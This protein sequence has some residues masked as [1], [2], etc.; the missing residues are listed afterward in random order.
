M[1]REFKRNNLSW[2]VRKFQWKKKM[3]TIRHANLRAKK[4]NIWN[5][6]LVDGVKIKLNMPV[7]WNS[8]HK[9]LLIAMTKFKV[10]RDKWLVGNEYRPGDLCEN[11]KQSN[12]HAMHGVPVGERREKGA[13][14]IWV[15][16]E[17]SHLWLEIITYRFKN[18]D[19]PQ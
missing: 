13:K 9:V 12:I 15:I 18:L 3:K 1:L 19:K 7:E 11:I 2:S 8:A 14:S 4:Y 10:Q 17:T 16:A 6:N 5:E